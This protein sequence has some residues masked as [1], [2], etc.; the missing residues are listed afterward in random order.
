MSE[1]TENDNGPVA[2]Y[3]DAMTETAG[4]QPSHSADASGVRSA[5]D[6]AGMAI[7]AVDGASPAARPRGWPGASSGP[8]TM[9]VLAFAVL[10]AAYTG[11]RMP[12]DWTATLDSVSVTDGFHRRFLV[13]TLLHPL[14]L[15]TG[16]NYWV[17]AAKDFLVLGALLAVLTVAVIKAKLV[18][19]RLL[20]IG[21]LLL[22]TGGF[23]F[24]E[25]GYYD[26]VIYLLL[27]GALWL[28]FRGRP[29][30][31]CLLITAGV[32]VHEI[33]V[34]T[35]LPV[36]AMV[37]LRRLSLRRAIALLLPPVLLGEFVLAVSP[38]A[39]GAT[40]RLSAR[41]HTANFPF[42]ADALALFDRTQ[43][44][45]WQMY[46]VRDTLI[47]L[48]PF[49]LLAMLGL[50]L[51]SMAD[52]GLAARPR[53]SRL[54]AVVH[55]AIA[56]GAVGGP[57]LLAFAGW[58]QDRWGFLL[59]SNLVIVLWLQ[60]RDSKREMG[61]AQAVTLAAALLVMTHIPLN[62]F[63]GFSPRPFQWPAVLQFASQVQDG[64]LF[65]IPP[66]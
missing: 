55:A 21:W 40:A 17:F 64:S 62:Y 38:A 32:L 29:V 41:L 54:A 53:S 10:V 12:N 61:P 6:P 14:A 16:Y 1:E 25:V 59:V 60:L 52:G 31:A 65:A 4:A 19:Q 22:P 49:A 46:S 13:G 15:A 3:D 20:V 11:F 36:F 57:T 8:V 2:G 37:V 18:S 9:G 45:T 30:S 43:R 26:Q 27:C 56:C 66:R 5:D 39:P 28:V 58:D 35:V 42:R 47:Y 7:P 33:A 63:D 51:L 48:A 23:L 24:D 50:V 34:L 44:Q